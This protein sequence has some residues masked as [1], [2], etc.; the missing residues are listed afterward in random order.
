MDCRGRPSDSLAMTRHFSFSFSVIA[1]SGATKQSSLPTRVFRARLLTCKILKSLVS[2]IIPNFVLQDDCSTLV[3]FTCF[4]NATIS[5][6]F[7][8]QGTLAQ[9]FHVPCFSFS[10][11]SFRPFFYS[12]L[13]GFFSYFGWRGCNKKQKRLPVKTNRRS[14]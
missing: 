1:R 14:N 5:L 12:Y 6:C 9:F 2:R 4:H 3:L 11:Y 8:K 7:S 13:V 10:L